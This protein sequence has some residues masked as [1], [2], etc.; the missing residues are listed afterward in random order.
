MSLRVY[1]SERFVDHVTPPEFVYRHKWQVGDL[2]MWDNC[3]MQHCAIA[4]YALPQRR[5]LQKTTLKGSAP[6]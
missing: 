5:W 3:S 4:D 2:V 1:F 6:F